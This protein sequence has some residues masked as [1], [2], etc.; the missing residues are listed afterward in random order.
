METVTSQ[1]Q[2]DQAVTNGNLESFCQEVSKRDEDLKVQLDSRLIGLKKGFDTSFAAALPMQ[3]QSFG[4]NVSDIK[5]SLMRNKR[6]PEDA[7]DMK[8]GL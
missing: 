3:S 4:R 8:D 5:R 6:A 7:E 2:K 1:I